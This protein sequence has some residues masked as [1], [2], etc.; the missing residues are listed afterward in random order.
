MTAEISR[1]NLLRTG[2]AGGLGIAIAGSV[3]A[4]AGPAAAQVVEAAGPDKG[5]GYGPVV[6]DPKGLLSLPKG[7]SYTIVAQAG[8][9]KLE[10][11]EPTP[12]DTDGTGFFRGPKGG[13]VLVNNH[14]I[15]GDEKYGVPALE[16]LTYDAGGRG[17][18]TNIVVDKDGRRVREYV[19]L[20]GTVQNCAGGVTPWGT[21][22]TCEETEVKAG[23]AL[24][25]DHGYVFDVDPFDNDLNQDPVPLKFLGRFSHE[26][27][28]VDPRT[29]IIYETEDADE[30]NGL[31]FRWVPP[32]GFRPGKGALKRL[33][34][35]EGGDTAGRL[36]AMKCTKGGRHI[37]DL[38]QATRPGTRYKVTWVD[39]PD[40]DAKT[41]SVRKQFTDEE[42]TRSR[43]L[44]GQWWAD[45]GAY[46]VASYARHDDGSVNEHDGQ[47]WFYDPESETVTLK[48]IF[49]VNPD[50]D[51]DTNYDGPDN[52]TVSP[53]GGIILAEDGD[54]IQHLVGVTD[55]GTVYPLA[56]NEL[57]DSEFAGPVFSADG[58]V[59][60][61]GIQSPGYVFAITGPWGG[62]GRRH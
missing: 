48:T 18:T 29:S 5:A 24:K 2:A 60:Y 35:S 40:R 47:V 12:S 49:G 15:G 32:K 4:I 58:K 11:G 53:Y 23:G 43:K 38:S 28:A 46:F 19:S 51:K 56:R 54:G 14:E 31:Y 44:E 21:W 59:L 30:P 62:R 20:A 57:N 7:F 3:E 41:T 8:G 9:T 36:Q 17:G 39:V 1:R 37:A 61:V 34:L 25:K 22:L 33:A 26:A 42:V 6:K 52:I 27:V 10:S 55:R 50:P 45:G 13:G 16:G